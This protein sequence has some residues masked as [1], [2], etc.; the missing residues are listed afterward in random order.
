MNRIYLSPPDVGCAERSAVDRALLSGWVAPLGPELDAF[1]ADIAILAGRIHAVGLSSGTAALHLALLGVGVG[2]GDEVLTSTLTF[3][4][5]ANAV[6]YCGAQPVFIDS[7]LATWNMSPNLLEEE[8]A[9]RAAVGR[10]PAA[11]VAVDLYGQCADYDSIVRVCEYYDVPVI[12]D[13]AESLGASYRGQPAGSFGF[14]AIFSFNGNKIVT[15]SGGGML[16]TDD[17]RLAQRARYLAT[18]ARGPFAHYEHSEVGY[19]YRLSNILA[20]LGR[21]QVRRLPEL[22]QRRK[23]VNARYRNALADIPGLTFQSVGTCNRPNYW[24]TCMLID[25]AVHGSS[26]EELR[27]ALEAENIETRPLWKP[28]HLQPVFA[29]APRRADGTSEY[30]FRRGLCLPSGSSLTVEDQDR[31]IGLIR[32]HFKVGME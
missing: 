31:I 13:A 30:L 12:E 2:R 25:P 6:I 19:N 29:S 10:R 4:A 17:Q 24:I 16:V 14:A 22:V 8:L 20:A 15:T 26:P 32:R 11:V 28:M 7:D 21:A 1:E 18:Q 27:V 5:T 23:R 9:K 3:A